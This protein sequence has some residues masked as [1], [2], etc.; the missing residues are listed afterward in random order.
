MR[1]D[2]FKEIEKEEKEVPDEEISDEEFEQFIQQNQ[3]NNNQDW[4]ERIAPVLEA[5]N[6][7]QENLEESLSDTETKK[8]EEFRNI[9]YNPFIK[10]DLNSL[11]SDIKPDSEKYYTKSYGELTD[12]RG[13]E[14]GRS[15]IDGFSDNNVIDL[16]RMQQQVNPMINR[17]E[18][19][20]ER[21]YVQLK[22]AEALE[23]RGL[24]FER[25]TRKKKGF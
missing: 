6:D 3:F 19:S 11:Y 23:D 20:R 14:V 17:E 10:S 12:T 13:F 15:L 18:G 25:V 21:H 22:Q 16:S 7:S 24:P 4:G 2:E 1:N 8:P 9:D 5:S